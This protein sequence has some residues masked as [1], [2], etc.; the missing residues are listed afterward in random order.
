MKR[1]I[2]DAMILGDRPTG[3]ARGVIQHL[4][5]I[6]EDK[7]YLILIN[8]NFP[9]ELKNFNVLTMPY[10]HLTF[11][12]V[13]YQLFVIPLLMIVLNRLFLFSPTHILPVFKCGHYIALMNDLMLYKVPR[14]YPRLKSAAYHFFYFT[15]LMNADEFI[16]PSISTRNDLSQ[17]TKKK[18]S[19]HKLEIGQFPKIPI[20]VKE[21]EGKKFILTVVSMEKGKNLPFLLRSY[22]LLDPKVRRKFHL[23]LT[24]KNINEHYA[25]KILIRELGL[26]D[27][28]L[29][30]GYVSDAQLAWLYGNC[31]LFVLPSLYEGFGLPVLEAVYFGALTICSDTSSLKEVLP[32]QEYRFS[33]YDEKK[34]SELMLSMLN[35]EGAEEYRE[36]TRDYRESVL[37][38]NR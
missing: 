4:E 10:S 18:I 16:V 31:S 24:G 8:R 27:S 32:F 9:L 12:R 28:I 38:K 25:L 11:I 15:A 29:F 13:L 1:K 3:V 23:A 6:R 19:I 30:T 2:F 22:S 20:P 5:N 26:E 33:P 37:S 34:C 17:H 35:E 21:L 14:K 7:S 36:K